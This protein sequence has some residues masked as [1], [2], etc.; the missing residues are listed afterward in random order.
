MKRVRPWFILAAFV[1]TFYTAGAWADGKPVTQEKF[2]EF[3][4]EVIRLLEQIASDV[5][6]LRGP[7]LLEMPQGG[8]MSVAPPETP[9]PIL[10]CVPN[11]PNLFIRPME[12]KTI[13]GN[14]R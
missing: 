7:L 12:P 1:V 6:H 3:Q 9:N 14:M 8:M 10:Y 13:P 2:Q 5:K 11:G 4:A